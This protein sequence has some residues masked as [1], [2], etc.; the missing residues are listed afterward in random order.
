MN[1]K[2][3]QQTAALTALT[4]QKNQEKYDI[5]LQQNA[6]LQTNIVVV[7]QKINDISANID[8]YVANELWRTDISALTQYIQ[9]LDG[10]YQSIDAEIARLDGVLSN[11]KTQT[12]ILNQNYNELKTNDRFLEFGLIQE[13]NTALR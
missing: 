2:I 13:Q 9:T 3:K 11:Y 4:Q 8:S 12:T 7:Q 5:L 10:T 1:N 6:V